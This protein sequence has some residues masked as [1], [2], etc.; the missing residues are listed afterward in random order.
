MVITFLKYRNDDKF[1]GQGKKNYFKKITGASVV[2]GMCILET[3]FFLRCLM[4][5][6][7]PFIS[8]VVEFVRTSISRGPD[9]G[10][11]QCSSS[12][13]TLQVSL[14]LNAAVG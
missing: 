5:C 3:T 9:D 10:N 1:S 6:H 7:A 11:F 4:S 8:A 2:E 14:L 13:Y 12:F